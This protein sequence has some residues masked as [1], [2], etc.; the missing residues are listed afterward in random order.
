MVVA[1][2]V[3]VVAV[4]ALVALEV[5]LLRAAGP[6]AWSLVGLLALF[7]IVG[8]APGPERFRRRRGVREPSPA[9]SDRVNRVVERLC[10]AA[11]L[12]V[13]PVEVLPELPSLAWTTTRL[14][15]RP[16][17]HVT[18]GLLDRLADREVEAVLAHELAHIAHRDAVV[19]GFVGAPAMVVLRGVARLVEDEGRVRGTLTALLI[20]PLLP[21]LLIA[22]LSGRIL[23]RH[24]EIAADRT[25]ALMT[26]SPAAVAAAILRAREGMQGLAKGYV[27]GLTAKD[28]YHFVPIRERRVPWRAQPATE[29]RVR[30]LERMEAALQ[31][32]SA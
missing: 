12:D 10:L 27:R 23:S 9:D 18:T 29:A 20:L 6:K 28:P 30:R 8:A 7:A 5:A 31:R 24:R 2:A 25:A 15:R 21:A 32:P 19:M 11:G 26:G 4:A 1:L 16:K 14:G 17:L 3:H 22:G 13:P